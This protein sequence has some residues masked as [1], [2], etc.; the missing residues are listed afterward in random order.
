VL[1]LLQA[2]VKDG[3]TLLVTSHLL[4]DIS[5]I[6][7]QAT[8]LARGRVE[9]RGDL[10][11]MLRREGVRSYRV[12]QGAAADAAMDD[13]VRR[14]VESAGGRVAAAGPAQ[15]SIE[16]LFLETYRRQE[17]GATGTPPGPADGGT[18]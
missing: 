14:A 1:G 11:A 5:G 8:L 2:H 12:E 4:G 16:D 7:T 17:P 15:G 3:G 6:A 9:R 13:A 18:A 10:G